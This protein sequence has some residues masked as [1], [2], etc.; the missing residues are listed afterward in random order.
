MSCVVRSGRS[1]KAAAADPIAVFLTG[2]GHGDAAGHGQ[3]QKTGRARHTGAVGVGSALYIA[4]AARVELLCSCVRC[5]LLTL[6]FAAASE[7]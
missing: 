4:V 1:A 6:D 7:P 5:N 2:D 3:W